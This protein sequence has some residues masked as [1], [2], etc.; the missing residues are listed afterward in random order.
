MFGN[1]KPFGGTNTFQST[2]FGTASP[3]GQNTSAFGAAKPLGSGFGGAPF[4]SAPPNTSIFS[5][6]G[7]TGGNLFGSNT[8][9]TFGQPSTSATGFPVS[10]FTATPSGGSLFN[11]TQNATGSSLFQSPSSS[12]FGA[13]KST[14]GSFGGTNTG[15]L[16]GQNQQPASAL[17]N[18]SSTASTGLFSSNT[19]SFTPAFGGSATGPTGTTIKFNPVNGT[20]TMIKNGVNSTISIRHQCITVMKEYETKSLEELRMEDYLSN[21]KGPQQGALGT[22]GATQPSLFGSSTATPTTGLFQNQNKPLFGGSNTFGTT[23]NSTSVF[24]QPMQQQNNT[25]FGAAKPVTFGTPVATTAGSSFNFN[26]ATGGANIFGSSTANQNKSIFG[27]TTNQPAT[28]GLFGSTMQQPATS[29]GSTVFGA[30]PFTTQNQ[31][32]IFGNK[33]GFGATTTAAQ[34]FSFVNQTNTTPSTTTPFGAKPNT[35]FGAPFGA[36]GSSFG[37]FNSGTSL[38]NQNKPAATFGNT[39]TTGFGAGI[40]GLGTSGGSIFS[41]NKPGLSLGTGFGTN[42]NT[43][44][45]ANTGLNFMSNTGLQNN[46][47]VL[48]SDQSVAQLAQQQTQ[49]QQQLLALAQSPFGDSPLFR[50]M[51]Q[52]LSKREEVL[53]PTNPTAQRALSKVNLYKISPRPS[54]KVK[55]QPLHVT[56]NGKVSLFDGLDEDDLEDPLV[57]F[58]PRKSVKKLNLKPK[59]LTRVEQPENIVVTGSLFNGS[60]DEPSVSSNAYKQLKGIDSRSG[61]DSENKAPL[62]NSM[63]PTTDHIAELREFHINRNNN[64]SPDDTI[65]DLNTKHKKQSSEN[66]DSEKENADQDYSVDESAD[67]DSEPEIVEI[68]KAHPAGI[69]LTRSD[70][71]TIPSMNELENMVTSSGDCFVENFTIGRAGYG[72]VYFFGKTN[73]AGMNFDEIVHFR[74]KQIIIYPDNDNKPPLGEGLNKKAQITLDGVWPMD[75]TTCKNAERLQAMQYQVFLERLTLTKLHA[76]FI[77]YRPDTGSWVFQVSHFSKYGLDDSDEDDL[78][79]PPK[80]AE[81]SVA[82]ASKVL[83]PKELVQSRAGLQ[84]SAEKDSTQRNATQLGIEHGFLTKSTPKS[85]FNGLDH[86]GF[87][88]ADDDDDMMDMS[89]QSFKKTVE[90]D[91]S[92]TYEPPSHRLAVAMDINSQKMQVMKASLF[93]DEMSDGE[94]EIVEDKEN[95]MR[96]N[97]LM[98]RNASLPLPSL[99]KQHDTDGTNSDSFLEQKQLFYRERERAPTPLKRTGICMMDV[100]RS[101]PP[102]CEPELDLSKCLRLPSAPYIPPRFPRTL[103]AGRLRKAIPFT[104]SLFFDQQHLIADAAC[105]MGRRF[106]VGWGPNWTLTQCATD[107]HHQGKEVGKADAHLFLPFEKTEKFKAKLDSTCYAVSVKKVNVGHIN[108]HKDRLAD[109]EECLAIQFKHSKYA[110]ENGCPIVTASPGVQAVH[111]LAAHAKEIVNSMSSSHPD[112]S[113]MNHFKDV[114]DLC[115]SLWGNIHGYDEVV[116]SGNTHAQRMARRKVFTQWLRSVSLHKIQ[117]EVEKKK[118]E[119][120]GHVAAILSHLSGCQTNQAC[121]LAQSGADHRLA[122]LL[123]QAGGSAEFKRMMQKQLENW[124]ELKADKYISNERLK[125]FALLAGTLVWPSSI[126]CINTCEN[127]DWKRALAIHLQYSCSSTASITDALLEYQAAFKGETTDGTYCAP[128]LPPYLEDHHLVQ[129]EEKLPVYDVCYHLLKLYMK[130]SHRL[131]RVLCPSAM[132]ANPLDFRLSWLLYQSLLAIGYGHLSETAANN[133]H[134]SFAAQLESV[135]LWCWAVFVIAHISDPKKRFKLITELLTRH[136]DLKTD[137]DVEEFLHNQL[138]IPK[139]WISLA[140]A[141]RAAYEGNSRDEAYHLL[142]AGRWSQSHELVLRYIAPDAIINESYNYLRSFLVELAP[143]DRSLTIRDWNIGGQVYLDYIHVSQT[144]EQVKKGEMGTYELEDLQPNV[145][146]LCSRVANIQCRTAKDRLC[147]A[148]MAKKT[149]NLLRAVL[150]LQFGDSIPTRLLVPHLINLPLPED[151]AIQELRSFAESNLCEM[152]A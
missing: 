78:P 79:I 106:R 143:L 50:N 5:G 100:S 114:W 75:K 19:G 60:S 123:A 12:A 126:G 22:F 115:V 83:T 46:N 49:A 61:G 110:I 118:L 9:T 66:D 4:G 125:I 86:S 152:T 133:L 13:P 54:A 47:V 48:G 25:M 138:L 119:K 58:V 82:A 140:K 135:G 92:E 14:F 139:D 76:K 15:N 24:G 21:R 96:S 107:L 70:Y 41:A 6:S 29:F 26:N 74:K 121:Q 137:S 147:Q 98:N 56:V 31:T 130:R 144:I 16:F 129:H 2:S 103:P 11:S 127:L 23:P 149:A 71:Y 117:R 17:F 51:M 55:P 105:F 136:I 88:V 30:A 145:K 35:G 108:E 81:K 151:Y 101:T 28:G 73:V 128:P 89:Q 44:F 38:F 59:V 69:V 63:I 64:S 102:S 36:T 95:M 113:F 52:D 37:G 91:D 112:Y 77:D 94:E 20:D 124:E 141:S 85:I 131:E 10:S 62:T 132:T 27:A 97:I 33:T 8:A 84:K 39:G 7:T 57:A 109:L 40:G 18:A 93:A 34:S 146:S 87:G 122:L 43:G 53:K 116:E 150:S 134:T 67:N 42:T 32:S 65:A 99:R 111:K 142:K 45:G 72:N 68:E 1:N 90:T 120:D 148:E 104:R 80:E 3:F